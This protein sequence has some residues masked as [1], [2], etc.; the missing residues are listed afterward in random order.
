[1]VGFE[2]GEDCPRADI[3]AELHVYLISSDTRGLDEKFDYRQRGICSR[4]THKVPSPDNL[5]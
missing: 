2:T 1:M 4:L 3:G 5:I